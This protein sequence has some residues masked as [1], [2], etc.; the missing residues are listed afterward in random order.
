MTTIHI[1]DTVG[2]IVARQPALS[3]AF[4]EAGIDYCCGGK[5]TLE[6]AC[7]KQGIDPQRFLAALA[8]AASSDETPLIDA[9]KMSLAALADHIEETHHAYLRSELPRL[10]AMTQKVASVHGGNEPR[11][12]Q[13]HETFVAL[14]EELLSHMMKEERILFPMVREIEASATAPQFHC[15]SLANPIRQMEAEHE[16]AGSALETLRELT[17]GY[18]PPEWACNTYRAMLDALARLERDMHHHVHKENNVLF[19]RALAMEHEKAARAEVHAT[20]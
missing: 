15:G 19:P 4:E 20:Q 14:C 6:E 3:R 10:D 12:L 13:V 8:N 5:R 18:T 2:E 7:R 1:H 17:D 11:L 16:H 9:A